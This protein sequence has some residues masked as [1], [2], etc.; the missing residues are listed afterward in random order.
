MKERSAY[1]KKIIRNYYEN[2]DSIMIQTLSEIIS[3]LYIAPTERRRAQLW[4]RAE[5]ALRTLGVDEAEIAQIMK[6]RDEKALA[7]FVGKAF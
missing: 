6:S 1:Q 4:R 2:R 7:K 5:K 3:E